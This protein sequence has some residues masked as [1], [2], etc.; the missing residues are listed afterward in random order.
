MHCMRF[1]NWA[2]RLSA[3]VTLGTTMLAQ[4]APAPFPDTWPRGLSDVVRDLDRIA[5]DA[6]KNPTDIGYTIGVVTR[7]GL[8]WTRSYGF[9]DPGRQSPATSETTYGAGAGALT[10]IMLLQLV[11]DGVVHF[12]D[13]V[14]RYVPEAA[15]IRSAYPNAAPVTLLQLATH[16]SGLTLGD[17]GAGGS[18]P[19]ESQLT[20]LLPRAS[21]EFEPGTHAEF[22]A[23]NE[24]VLAL[25][26]SH[27]ARQPYADY[28]KQ[29]ILSPLG[30]THS[31]F[32]GAGAD[33]RGLG[34][35]PALYTTVSDLGKLGQF[36]LGGGPDSVLATSAL[37]EN[38]RRV[39]MVNAVSVPNPSEGYG[40][41][42]SGE[43][44]TSNRLSHYYF[45]L[46]FA[47]GGPAYDATMWFEPR[48]HAGVILLHHGGAGALGQMIHSYVYTLNAQPIDAGRQEPAGPRPYAEEAVSVHNQ[49]A[50]VTL[51]GTLSIP[52]GAGPFPAVLLIARS[53]PL[54][55][56]EPLLNHRPFLVLA[57]FL[58]RHGI[59]VLRL[60]PRGV[61]KSTGKPASQRDDVVSDGE[62]ALAFLESRREVD[63]RRLGLI[64]HE[65]GSVVAGSLAARHTG[66]AFVVTMGAPAVPAAVNAVEA[67]RLTSIANG[68]LPE[69]AAAQAADTRA[70][71]DLIRSE[72]D[73]AVLETKL[74]ALLRGKLPDAQLASQLRVWTSAPFKRQLTDDPAVPFRSLACPVL[75]LYGEK[76]L[77]F[78]AAL[79]APA[80]RAALASAGN[81]RSEVVEIPDVNLLFQT[82]DVG[83]GREANWAEETM[84]PRV[85]QAI[86]DWIA[87]LAHA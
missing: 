54:D 18:G 16:S 10:A 22:S 42:F 8:S 5:A 76:D 20:D 24:A 41:G 66:I 73:P 70:A 72:T 65:D 33:Q 60:D 53:G 4:Q 49:T 44:W 21:F 77:S 59:V 13:P 74:R 35:A 57:D 47:Y 81:G 6:V 14:S 1:R 34:Y 64:A 55:R 7:D 51:A 17:A 43:T 71:Y 50:G 12:S 78:P 85:M 45:I 19:W 84:A 40:V 48:T 15:S 80:M 23:V 36:A 3:C 67:S 37:E 2:L 27:A 69:R 75:A 63:A 83:V 38:Y 52:A 29:R 31:D 86:A 87:S 11:R 61:G 46:P 25:A 82:A 79:N 28:I 68:G 39:W 30:M 58:A 62:A 9:S 32:T 26:L 56:D